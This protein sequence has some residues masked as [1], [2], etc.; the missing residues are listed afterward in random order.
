[1]SAYCSFDN[2]EVTD[3]ELMEDYVA[4]VPPTVEA[5]GGRYVVVGGPWQVVEG[6]WHPAYPVVIEFPTIEDANRWYESDEYR[7]LRDQRHA[8]GAFN[9]VFF[10]DAGANAHT[11]V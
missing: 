9:A 6:D 8:A 5:F 3:P 2:L 11:G 4:R 1:M 10:D 7:P